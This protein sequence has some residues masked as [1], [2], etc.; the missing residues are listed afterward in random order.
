[1]LLDTV[2]NLMFAL[3]LVVAAGLALS[4]YLDGY[5]W[6]AAGWAAV[7]VALVLVERLLQREDIE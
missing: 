3:S 6:R 1:M 2:A 5:F 7:V 4:E